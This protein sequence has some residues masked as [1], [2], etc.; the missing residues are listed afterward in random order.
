MSGCRVSYRLRPGAVRQ[1]G[2]RS[3]P[4]VSSGGHDIATGACNSRGMAP[5]ASCLNLGDTRVSGTC[6]TK[7]RKQRP[8]EAAI[9]CESP[10]PRLSGPEHPLE[11]DVHDAPTGPVEHPVEGRFHRPPDPRPF[12]LIKELDRPAVLVPGAVLL[13]EELD[14][15]SRVNREGLKQRGILRRRERRTDSQRG[16]LDARINPNSIPTCQST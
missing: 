6:W 8:I 7:S 12:A 16:R 11:R 9:L 1:P 5:H 2:S 3:G 4:G 15:R 13:P 10:F 14:Q